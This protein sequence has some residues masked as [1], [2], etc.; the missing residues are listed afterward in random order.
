MAGVQQSSSIDVPPPQSSYAPSSVEVPQTVLEVRTKLSNPTPY[1]V[2]AV[3]QRQVHQFLS[4]QGIM[5]PQSRSAPSQNTVGLMAPRGNMTSYSMQKDPMLS[6]AMN[7]SPLKPSPLNPPAM[8]VG[9]GGMYG[10][11][12]TSLNVKSESPTMMVTDTPEDIQEQ[13][14]EDIMSLEEKFGDTLGGM[15]YLE[16]GMIAPQTLPVNTN[17]FDTFGNHTHGMGSGG[18]ASPIVMSQI[19]A[20][21]PANMKE[22]GMVT[23]G[24]Y[25]M[26]T[27]LDGAGLDFKQYEKERQKKN[28]HNMIERRRRF[29]INDR[30]KELGMLLPPSESEARQNKGTI[31]KASVDYIKKMQRDMNKLKVQEAKQRQ[32]EETNRQMRLRIQELELT[33]RAHGIATPS[34]SA[35]TQKLADAAE[36]ALGSV[37]P[38]SKSPG[39]ATV[40]PV[41]MFGND[42]LADIL[43]S[44]PGIDLSKL[45]I[46]QEPV[47]TSPQVRDHLSPSP[48]PSSTSGFDHQPRVGDIFSFNLP[49]TT[50]SSGLA[51]V[52]RV[53][54]DSSIQLF[55]NT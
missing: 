8:A 33:A 35:E 24:E 1:H 49:I 2:N 42:E 30:I 14:I 18:G 48:R 34:L 15:P 28:N 53:P 9:G 26:G 11:Q 36:H 10:S 6:G 41:S 50:S 13:I 4:S 40:T 44:S 32:L 21:C 52:P 22:D 25:A 39:S 17:L 45:N 20:S 3:K 5:L 43:R 12:P 55:G 27:D 23:P 16:S 29:N 19:S 37:T 47:D 51:G 38:R 46:K 31:L 54:A 7:T